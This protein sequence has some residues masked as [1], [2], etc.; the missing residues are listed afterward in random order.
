MAWCE[1]QQNKGDP[2]MARPIPLDIPPSDPA[3]ELRS[4]LE[5]AQAQ[6]AEAVLAAYEVLQALHDQG[7]LELLRGALGARDQILE[8][9]VTAVNNPETI[10]AIRNLLFWRRILGSIEPAWFKGMFQAIPEGMAKA[11]AGQGKKVGLWGLWRRVRSQDSLRAMS[12]AMDFL[13]AFGRQLHS[14]EDLPRT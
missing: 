3:A 10:R 4:R 1:S 5:N 2:I 9:A 12:A 14:L 8:T 7:V 6:H 13:E 11:T